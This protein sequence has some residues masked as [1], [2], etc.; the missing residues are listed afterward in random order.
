MTQKAPGK[1]DR[2]GLSLVEVTRIFPTDEA[3]EKWFIK[4]R[5]P[6]GI[7]CPYCES[8]NGQENAK[9]A[10]M[11]HRCRSCRRR[12]SVRTGTIM[13]ASNL[14]YQTWAFAM[15]L[16]LT[17]LKSVASMKLHRDLAITQK[18]AWHLA[19]RLRKAFTSDTR[20][21]LGPVEVDET[22]IGGK[23]SNRHEHKKQGTS[24]GGKA[25]VA[26]AKDRGARKI[27]ARMV[28]GTD[29]LTLKAFV[30]DVADESATVYSDG[31]H[32]YHTLP[33]KHESVNHSAG[34]FVRGMAHTNGIESFWSMLKRGYHGT[35]H[36]FSKKHLQRYVNEFSA[37][38]NVRE[39]DTIQQM[40]F[41]ARRMGGKRLKY[42]DLIA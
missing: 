26:G 3:A 41:L 6:N 5:W 34:E 24:T 19:H 37:R 7:E 8:A 14:G 15:Y 30:V 39:M 33:H 38:Y 36:H 28:E 35:F 29:R 10:T 2:E 18:S 31:H 20:K 23:D 21:F 32:A 25:I 13:Q 16:M 22:Y 9:H 1:A 4:M 42:E 12:F 11:P 17:S 40:G 27:Q